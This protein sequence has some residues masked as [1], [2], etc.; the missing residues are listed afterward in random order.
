[1]DVPKVASVLNHNRGER[2]VHW[3]T[4]SALFPVESRPVLKVWRDE[5]KALHRRFVISKFAQATLKE[6]EE[7]LDSVLVPMT[8]RVPDEKVCKREARAALKDCAVWGDTDLLDRD[9]K[10]I[11]T[12]ADNQE[13]KDLPVIAEAVHYLRQEHGVSVTW[14]LVTRMDASYGWDLPA[15]FEMAWISDAVVVFDGLTEEQ[16]SL[17]YQA[18]D[19]FVIASQAEGACLPVYEALA[20]DLPVV[21]PDHTAL[22]EVVREHGFPVEATWNTVHPW[23]TVIRHHV[24]P[25]D[26]QMMILEAHHPGDDSL[27]DFIKS[28]TWKDAAQR[29]QEAL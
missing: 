24:T 5:L 18:A 8:A 11:L 20:H 4:T 7:P 19:V 1:M 3:P 14:L 9:N 22:S 15:L 17:A 2:G 13:R 21:A 6:H 12:V 27:V 26:L 23:G 25:E 16:L 29:I 28:R 10:F